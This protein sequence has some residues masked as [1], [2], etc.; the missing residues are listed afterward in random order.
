LSAAPDTGLD[1][2]EERAAVYA[3]VLDSALDAVIVVDEAGIVVTLNPAAETT[4]G[5]ARR[6]ALGH[7]I[8]DLIV[9]DHLKQAHETGIARYRATGEPRVLGRRV[10]MEA[11][12]KDG[13]VIPVELAITEV[14]LPNRRLFTANLR[15]LS[16]ARAAAAE[17][18][19]QRAALDQSEKLAAL[20][21]LLA[22]VAH[23]L[24]NPLS[25]VLGNAV[26]LREEMEANGAKSG[27]VA[28]AAK[29]ETAAERCAR[30]VRSF[31]AIARRHKTEKRAVPVTPLLDDSLRLVNYALQSN[32]IVVERDYDGPVPDA[33]VDRDQVQTV[34]VNL[35]VNAVQALEEVEGPRTIRISARVDGGVRV[36][37]A[38]SGPGIAADIA[39]RIFDPFFTTKPQGVGTGIGLSISRGLAE[40]QGGQLLLLAEPGEGAAFELILPLAD[41]GA[42]GVAAADGAE[43]S[44]VPARGGPRRAIVIDDEPDIAALLAESLQRAGYRCDV[45][46]SGREA[47]AL[48]SAH[49]GYA[50]VLCDLRMPDIDGPALFRWMETHHPA[51]A[52]RTVFVTGA[53]LGPA[54]GRFL[55]EN[56]RPVL[57][58][59]FTPADIIR[60]VEAFPPRP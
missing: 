24:N 36:V 57:E 1:T 56:S 58:K 55:A 2:A 37:V 9:P 32:G 15:D 46:T 45:A 4:F 17:I 49:S 23:E 44:S 48:M 25:V 13:R 10:L 33:F 40:A 39:H 19:R 47:Q 60:L 16:A 6:E 54:T 52:E 53:A 50:A 5:Y 38:D 14:K 51:L 20:G 8:G 59:P 18:E 12:C 42:A 3:A 34:V 29:I 43:S 22:G 30:V 35:L 11:R 28:R 27:S 26:M 21:S 41:A 7:S 31:L